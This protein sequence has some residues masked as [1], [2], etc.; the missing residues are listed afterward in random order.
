MLTRAIEPRRFRGPSVVI[1]LAFV[2]GA[3][4]GVTGSLV[5]FL[6]A[7]TRVVVV[8]RRPEAKAQSTGPIGRCYQ[9]Q[10][11]GHDCTGGGDA[12]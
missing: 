7:P 11:G 10:L 6:L 1:S 3:L 9:S 4:V 5:G 8:E 2:A 12:N